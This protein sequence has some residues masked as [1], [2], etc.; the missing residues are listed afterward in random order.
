MDP[1]LVAGGAALAL[2]LYELA[3]SPGGAAPAAKAKKPTAASSPTRKPLDTA[4]SLVRKI[5]RAPAAALAQ[6]QD[7]AQLAGSLALNAVAPALP[8]TVGR[9]AGNVLSSA[10]ER[11]AFYGGEGTPLRAAGNALS[12]LGAAASKFDAPLVGIFASKLTGLRGASDKKQTAIFGAASVDTAATALGAVPILGSALGGILKIAA[13]T[14]E[15]KRVV[16][17]VGV[18]EKQAYDIQKKLVSGHVSEALS[19]GGKRKERVAKLLNAAQAATPQ[20]VANNL[21]LRA[22]D[23]AGREL[24]TKALDA[25]KKFLATGDESQL[26]VAGASGFVPGLKVMADNVAFLA[27]VAK[28]PQNYG[29]APVGVNAA[30]YAKATADRARA[31]FLAQQSSRRVTRDVTAPEQGDL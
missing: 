10:G 8:G 17:V 28:N 16:K 11:V 13:G 21:A 18:A 6:A 3:G 26:K 7:P 9:A 19:G 27:D 23:T 15:G 29:S 24:G 1:V 20:T 25:A 31:R 2:V 5:T 4:T 14:Y 12:S 22:Q 30:D